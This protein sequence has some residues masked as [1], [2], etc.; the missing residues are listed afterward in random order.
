MKHLVIENRKSSTF[1]SS[2]AFIEELSLIR[3]LNPLNPP[4]SRPH[5]GLRLGKEASFSAFMKA[6][7]C[8][9]SR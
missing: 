6:K 5:N 1:I 7:I 3:L 4:P 8:I 9:D 2:S